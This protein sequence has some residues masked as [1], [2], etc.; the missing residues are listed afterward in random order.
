MRCAYRRTWQLYSSTRVAATCSRVAACSGPHRVCAR[1]HAWGSWGGAEWKFD[2]GFV[3]PGSTNSWQQTIEA[4]GGSRMLP[5]ALLR[6]VC[7]PAVAVRLPIVTV[8]TCMSCSGNV[9]IETG[10]YDGDS[11]VSKS[12]VRV[13]YDA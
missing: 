12:L 8:R 3:M 13:F 10:F 11:L 2:F 1:V 5:A 6:Y 9:T 7:G 4:A